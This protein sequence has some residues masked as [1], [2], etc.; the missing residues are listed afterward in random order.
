MTD[1]TKDRGE[2]LAAI[3][4][5]VDYLSSPDSHG[6]S[7][8][9][10]AGY[11][12][13]ENVAKLLD[14]LGPLVDATPADIEIERTAVVS[15]AH[16]PEHLGMGDITSLTP[17]A[18]EQLEDGFLVYVGSEE[19]AP[20]LDDAED[21]ERNDVAIVLAVLDVARAA[22]CRWVRFDRDAPTVAGL[23]TWEW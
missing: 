18:A 1:T 22:G 4:S 2:L 5:D 13:A 16:L 20:S 23:P 11:E 17:I 19:A 6:G 12:L 9:A 15:T 10:A 21:E 7:A 8:D 14:A 3:R